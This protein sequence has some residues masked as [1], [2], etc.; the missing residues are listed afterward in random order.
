MPSVD[1]ILEKERQAQSQLARFSTK[2]LSISKATNSENYKNHEDILRQSHAE[3]IKEL[4]SYPYLWESKA[5]TT[6]KA[7]SVKEINKNF[8]SLH[9]ELKRLVVG[10][11]Q[12]H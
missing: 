6:R 11:D 8:R 4:R 2:S 5:E 1:E 3:K 12:Q 7:D 9:Y 10:Q